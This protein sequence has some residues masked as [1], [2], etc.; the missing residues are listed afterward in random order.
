MSEHIIFAVSM[1]VTVVMSFAAIIYYIR[2]KH[3]EKIEMHRKRSRLFVSIREEAMDSYGV[4]EAA[5]LERERMDS[6][7]VGIQEGMQQLSANI[8]VL[9]HRGRRKLAAIPQRGPVKKRI[10]WADEPLLLGMVVLA[11]GVL[12]AGLGMHLLGGAGF[13]CG[14]RL[15]AEGRPLSSGTLSLMAPL[16]LLPVVAVF[17][18]LFNVVTGKVVSRP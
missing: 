8:K 3:L 2:A 9:L 13:A 10:L 17:I 1:L 5:V 11:G 16:M 15:A 12:C 4:A 6:L 7:R 18:V 14:K